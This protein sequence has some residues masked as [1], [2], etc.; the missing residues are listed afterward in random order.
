MGIGWV[1]AFLSFP[2]RGERIG[3]GKVLHLL[4]LPVLLFARLAAAYKHFLHHYQ[5][6][7][8]GWVHNPALPHVAVKKIRQA[9][10][11]PVILLPVAPSTRV[12]ACF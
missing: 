9:V 10:P 7:F 12:A 1:P 11:F 8:F 6:S 4:S 5:G 3:F 2:L